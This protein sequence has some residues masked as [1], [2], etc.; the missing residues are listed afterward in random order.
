MSCYIIIILDAIAIIVCGTVFMFW[1][2]SL[3][4]VKLPLCC[5]GLS[6][7]DVELNL[8]CIELS[9]CCVQLSLFNVE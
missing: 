7:S 2:L 4:C 3:C 1:T 6:L 9:F 8:C 5:A